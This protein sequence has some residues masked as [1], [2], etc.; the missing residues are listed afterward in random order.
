MAPMM[1]MK[2]FSADQASNKLEETLDLIRQVNSQFKDPV[3]L[4]SFYFLKFLP[5]FWVFLKASKNQF[6][7]NFFLK[8][9]EFCWKV[10]SFLN[11]LTIFWR[12]KTITIKIWLCS[13]QELTTFVCVCIAEFLSMYE[14]ERLIQELTKKVFH[15]LFCFFKMFFRIFRTSIRTISSSISYCFPIETATAAFPA[16]SVTPAIKCSRSTWIRFD[17][18]LWN[19]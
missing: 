11:D 7:M 10:A 13:V 4:I 18:V 6:L 3:W 9:N 14:T 17:N 12:K 15:L 8:F 19:V 2:D 5:R 1:G 16:R